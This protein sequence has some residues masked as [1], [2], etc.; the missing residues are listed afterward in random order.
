[1]ALPVLRDGDVVVRPLARGDEDAWLRLREANREW[2]TPWEA[3]LPAGVP[4]PTMAFAAFV[5]QERRAWKKREAYAGVIVF[6]GQLVGRVSVGGIRWGAERGGAVGYWI[7][8]THAGRGITPRAV[9][10]LAKYALAQGL[11]RL[12][13]A[14]RPENEASL[15]VVEKL[16]FRDEGVRHSFLYIDG[17][18][19]DH[20]VFALVAEEPKKGLMADPAH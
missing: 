6:G 8:H 17:N 15:R 18:W 20:R 9:A 4:H 14:V 10:L 16:G 7:A 13:I 19:R 11:H 5:R 12:E 3:T 2:L 1:M